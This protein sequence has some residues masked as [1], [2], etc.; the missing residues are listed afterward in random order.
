M[1]QATISVRID[2]NDKRD[3]DTFCSDVGLNTSVAINLFVKA[4]LRERRIPFDISQSSDPF[5]SES[6]QKHL[7]KAI[8]E[9]RDGKGT[10]H[11]LIEVEDE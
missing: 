5:Y 6:N 2:E 7:M 8:Q 3:F 11:D 10:A 1:A 4:V 9:L